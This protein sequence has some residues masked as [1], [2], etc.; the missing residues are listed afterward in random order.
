MVSIGS[1][2]FLLALGGLLFMAVGTAILMTWSWLIFRLFTD[3]PILPLSPMVPRRQTPWGITSIVLAIAAYL[4]ITIGAITVYAAEKG[5]LASKPPAN[6]PRTAIAVAESADVVAQRTHVIERCVQRRFAGRDPIVVA[7]DVRA[8]GWRDFGI[9]FQGWWRQA[10]L[11]CVATLAAAPIVYTI[12]FSAVK[13]FRKS[14]A[15]PSENADEGFL[16]GDRGT[17][18]PD[19]GD[20]GSSV[21]RTALSRHHPE[22]AGWAVWLVESRQRNAPA[23][24]TCCR[25]RCAWGSIE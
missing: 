24:G 21:R 15:S 25:A 19:G 14:R 23:C 5:R 8:H 2:E 10:A 3:Q 16:T 7:V 17:G 20:C 6:L 22:L 1:S 9:S 18:D 12:Q 4:V 11:G 13:V